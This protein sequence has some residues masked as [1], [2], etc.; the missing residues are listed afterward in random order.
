MNF[1][2]LIISSRNG[3]EI[4]PQDGLNGELRRCA[5]LHQGE[6][7]L[8][9]SL[10][11]E[12]VHYVYLRH[13][14]KK[15]SNNFFGFVI[16]FNAVCFRNAEKVFDLMER[17]YETAVYEGLL[18]HVSDTG[19][20]E[21]N[22]QPFYEQKSQCQRIEQEARRMVDA[23]PRGS[24]VARPRNYRTGNGDTTINLSEGDSAV[25]DRMSI[26]DRV[27]IVREQS[28][29]GLLDMQ[30]RLRQLHEQST[31][32]EKKYHEEH[33][34]KKQYSLVVVLLVVLLV[35]GALVAYVIRDNLFKID[36][37][38]E[39]VE[40][41]DRNIVDKERVIRDQSVHIVKLQDTILS[42]NIQIKQMTDTMVEMAIKMARYSSITHAVGLPPVAEDHFDN[43]Y[44]MW[45]Y[46][47]APLTISKIWL[48]A[49]QSGRVRIVLR[50]EYGNYVDDEYVS[51]S[52]TFRDIH[53][54]LDI[55]YSGYYSLS[56]EDYGSMLFQYTSTD[57]KVYRAFESV[58]LRIIGCSN[59][60]RGYNS[61]EKSCYQYF[62]NIHY[63]M[64]L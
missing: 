25:A 14:G 41:R 7:T 26:Y 21:L 29:S 64:T 58:G 13:I 55:P 10:D 43:G 48:R 35:G 19:Q 2:L 24:F 59:R 45:L 32:W 51:V 20:V 8:V 54:S 5:A 62:Y 15:N 34:K 50:D 11:L 18:V 37:L 36:R 17:L 49:N 57:R 23:L 31:E 4:V 60:I 44:A 53:C 47:D 1:D 3:L 56:M 22:G 46:A 52:S 38:E 30:S 28:H 27:A 39:S 61:A 33:K 42:R 16:S 9:V 12:I 6:E 63:R 40:E